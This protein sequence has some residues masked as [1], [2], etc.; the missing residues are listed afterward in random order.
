MNKKDA[1]GLFNYSKNQLHHFSIKTT[2]TGVKIYK[3]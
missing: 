3:T 1:E 2:Y